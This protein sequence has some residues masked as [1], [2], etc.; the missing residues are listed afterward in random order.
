MTHVI[1]IIAAILIPL[2]GIIL[3]IPAVQGYLAR[4]QNKRR[5]RRAHTRN[6]QSDMNRV[7]RTIGDL[8]IQTPG[9][10]QHMEG[11]WE[12]ERMEPGEVFLRQG[13]RLLNLSSVEYEK[14]LTV[15][16]TGI[17]EPYR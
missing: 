10:L 2:I 4:G 3:S 5:Q 9:G 15:F 1:T 12:I 6:I 8:Y 17:G 16:R 13:S 7:G 11:Q 14:A